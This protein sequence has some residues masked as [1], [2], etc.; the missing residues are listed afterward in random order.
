MKVIPQYKVIGPNNYITLLYSDGS[1]AKV[2]L[3]MFSGLPY[4]EWPHRQSGIASPAEGCKIESRRWLS[5]TDSYYICTR[6]SR[7][8]AHEGEGCDQ[9][10]GHTVTNAMVVADCGRL[11]LVPHWVTSVDYCK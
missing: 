2:Q 9:S 8:T 11:Q 3:V 1:L 4:P 6:R 7:G 10:I 5:C